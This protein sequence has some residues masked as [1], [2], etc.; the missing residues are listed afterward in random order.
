[1]GS[2]LRPN[3]DACLIDMWAIL[4]CWDARRPANNGCP[5]QKNKKKKQKKRMAKWRIAVCT[6]SEN[7][8][9]RR[10]HFAVRTWL[11]G[12]TLL[13]ITMIIHIKGGWSHN[14]VKEYN[15]LGKPYT[16]QDITISLWPMHITIS[17]WPMHIKLALERE[18]GYVY[19]KD[20][21]PG[22]LNS[23]WNSTVFSWHDSPRGRVEPAG[24]AHMLCSF[25]TEYP[26]QFLFL[27]VR[28]HAL[29]TFTCTVASGAEEHGAE[30]RP[31]WNS[32]EI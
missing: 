21:T 12:V 10:S 11:R 13:W 30:E 7:L 5:C 29:H 25:R 4:H 8:A 19:M 9:Q 17:W 6:C 23:G 16:G 31:G 26:G 2:W 24:R 20:F 18:T 3:F 14:R 27:F 1:M 32:R 28:T 15:G 22:W